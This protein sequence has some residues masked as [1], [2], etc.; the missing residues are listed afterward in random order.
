MFFVVA[1]SGS[2]DW[3]D[4]CCQAVLGANA[5]VMKNYLTK[6]EPYLSDP[7]TFPKVQVN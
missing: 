4:G 3:C 6:Y 5:P 7:S 2:N 1:D